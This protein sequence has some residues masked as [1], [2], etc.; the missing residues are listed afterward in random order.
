MQ[1]YFD[2]IQDPWNAD[3]C[4]KPYCVYNNSTNIKNVSFCPFEDVLGIGSKH[5]F[6]S[7][8]VPG[9]GEA[10]PDSYRKGYASILV[11]AC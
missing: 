4:T 2:T 5:G 1:H 11:H 6:S 9:T 3:E 8:I 10:N 7:I